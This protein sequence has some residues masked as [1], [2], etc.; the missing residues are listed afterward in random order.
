MSGNPSTIGDSRHLCWIANDHF[1]SSEN[2]D[3]SKNYHFRLSIVKGQSS[4]LRV[5]FSEHKYREEKD[6]MKGP[7]QLTMGKMV[8][9]TL[10]SSDNGVG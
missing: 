10:I 2:L 8:A 7:P 4:Y 9:N 1:T 6:N 5:S 3:A